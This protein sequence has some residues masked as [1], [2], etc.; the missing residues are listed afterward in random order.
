MSEFLWRG[1]CCRIGIKDSLPKYTSF[2]EYI[3]EIF[4]YIVITGKGH[5]GL[6]IWLEKFD[7]STGSEDMILTTWY[8]EAMKQREINFQQ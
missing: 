8:N 6:D 1:I 7:Q 2:C 5:S 3:W 4:A